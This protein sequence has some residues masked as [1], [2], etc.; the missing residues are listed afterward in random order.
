MTPTVCPTCG[1]EIETF[2]AGHVLTRDDEGWALR[3]PNGRVWFEPCG[4][5]WFDK[6][7]AL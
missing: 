6:R 5:E 2:A 1:S 3:Y 4:H 7:V